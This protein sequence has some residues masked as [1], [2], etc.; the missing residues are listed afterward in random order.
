MLQEKLAMG[1]VQLSSTISQS[2]SRPGFTAL[3]QREVPPLTDLELKKTALLAYEQAIQL[4]PH[5]AILRF[6][7]GQVL[8]QLGR[9]GE[10]Q[11]EYGE[12]RRLGLFSR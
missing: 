1:T 11:Q 2:N 10:A 4:A 9:S 6:R 7:R 5:V 8:E 12:A 3:F